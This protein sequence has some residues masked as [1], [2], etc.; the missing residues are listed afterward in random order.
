MTPALKLK[1][2]ILLIANKFHKNGQNIKNEDGISL[3]LLRE[4]HTA[5][6]RHCIQKRKV[7]NYIIP[8]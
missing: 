6:K 3:E 2:W 1:D 5:N 8:F 4:I 7:M